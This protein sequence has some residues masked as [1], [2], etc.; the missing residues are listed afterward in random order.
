MCACAH[1]S[2]TKV[3]KN[4]NNGDDNDNFSSL[5]GVLFTFFVS[6]R[7]KNIKLMKTSELFRQYTWMIETFRRSGPL[8]L[9]DFNR[10]WVRS[11]FSDGR[12]MARSTFNHNREAIEE[13]FGVT[14]GCHLENNSYYIKNR[15]DLMDSRMQ[16][17]LMETISIG[18]M[19]SE[20]QTL[21][22]RILLDEIPVGGAT[23]NEIMK[24]MKQGV[25]IQILYRKFVD[26]QPKTVE[27][28]PLCLKAFN[29]RW[30]VV[31]DTPDHEEPALYSLDRIHGVELKKE[32]FTMPADFDA[33]SFFRDS[34]G[35][36][37]GSRF[38]VKH[39][40]LKAYGLQ[41]D[42]LRSLPLHR[43]QVET[44]THDG[45]SIFEYDIRQ[46]LDFVQE[47]L[48]RGNSIEVLSPADFR[49][50]IKEEIKK[51]IKLYE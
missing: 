3:Q 42:Y 16:R 9:K 6:L 20:S 50:H 45:W 30:Y 37:T 13:M 33:V 14:I 19:L 5:C 7:R 39:V 1:I 38:P 47:L 32:S 34:F 2:G 40:V 17:W 10:L 49:E 27:G 26:S 22:D 23:L 25:K 12:E 41:C 8:T 15:G 11:S 44:E 29:H 21:H 51:M 48:S 31:L 35:V 4:Y 24:A 43:S 36:F 18:T 46:T 28:A